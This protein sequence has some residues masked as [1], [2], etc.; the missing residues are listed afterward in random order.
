[1]R[2]E[3]RGEE[4]RGEERR[5]EERRGEERSEIYDVGDNRRGCEDEVL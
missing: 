3:R 1:M 4:R 5:G 2:K